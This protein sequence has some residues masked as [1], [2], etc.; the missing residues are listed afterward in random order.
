MK[1]LISCLQPDQE[2]RALMV[3]GADGL[4]LRASW[5]LHAHA[6]GRLLKC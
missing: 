2:S 4:R 6:A 5:E 3:V 1:L